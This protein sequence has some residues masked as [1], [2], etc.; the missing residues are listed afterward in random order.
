MVVVNSKSYL[1][2]YV[3]LCIVTIPK[4]ILCPPYPILL[5]F[6]LHLHYIVSLFIKLILTYD[7]L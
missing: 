5:F 6:Y 1:K 2:S 7:Q 4:I 3:N